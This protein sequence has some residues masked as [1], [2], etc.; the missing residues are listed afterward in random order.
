MKSGGNLQIS[1]VGSCD[2]VVVTFA[3]EGEGIQSDT[4]LRSKQPF[5]NSRAAR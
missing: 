3:D 1:L 5:G 4:L 2:R